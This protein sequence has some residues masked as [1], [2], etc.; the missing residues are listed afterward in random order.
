MPLSSRCTQGV[1]GCLTQFRCTC[2][3]WPFCL[4]TL[5]IQKGNPS[6]RK[7]VNDTALRSGRRRC[8]WRTQAPC[9]RRHMLCSKDTVQERK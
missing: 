2:V 3:C 9:L 6:K 1:G 4:G 5:S 8:R 7:R